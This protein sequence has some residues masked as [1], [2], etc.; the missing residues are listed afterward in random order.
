MKFPY[1]REYFLTLCIVGPA[2]DHAGRADTDV[3]VAVDVAVDVGVEEARGIIL[4]T[5]RLL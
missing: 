5:C 4:P 2:G 3:D 1:L